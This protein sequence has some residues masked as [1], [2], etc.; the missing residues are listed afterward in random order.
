ML[1]IRK[2]LI[3]F[4]NTDTDL[5]LHKLTGALDIVFSWFC[6][7]RLAVNPSKTEY[8][9]IGTSKQRSMILNSSIHFQ[10]NALIPSKSARNLGVIFDSEL[11]FKDHISS[12]CLSSFFQIRQLRQI[13]S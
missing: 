6:A 4:S 5:A 10:N 1:M 9:L 12:V 7:N 11:N 2:Y 3:S 13:R 8:L